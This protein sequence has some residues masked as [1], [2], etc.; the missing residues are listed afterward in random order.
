VYRSG[1]TGKVA[2]IPTMFTQQLPTLTVGSR[3]ATGAVAVNGAT[4]NVNYR[5][6]AISG[7]PGQFMTQTLNVT[8]P[9]GTTLVD[10]DVFTIAGVNAYDNRLQA[11]LARPQQFR[12]VGG[13]YTGV[14]NAATIRIFPAIIVPGSGAGDDVGINTA[15]ATVTAAPGATA[16]ITMLGAASSSRRERF[17]GQKSAV[18]CNTMDLILPATGIGMRKSLTK[19]PLSVRMWKNSEFAT[20]QHDVRFDVAISANVRDRRR[21]VRIAGA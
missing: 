2:G 6:V 3:V 12:V 5:D 20:G 18:V 10:G 15:H 14:S 21:V 7:A 9:T 8:L 16:A 13:P 1:F 11:S 19:L 17:I 4:Q